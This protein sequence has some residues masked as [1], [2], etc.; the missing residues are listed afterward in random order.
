[1]YYKKTSFLPY[2]PYLPYGIKR[3]ASSGLDSESNFKAGIISSWTDGQQASIRY[4]TTLFKCMPFATH[5]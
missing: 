2:L 5:V 3:L 1:M 4:F